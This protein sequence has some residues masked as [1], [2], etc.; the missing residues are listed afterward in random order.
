M[1]PEEIVGKFAN[2]LEQFKSINRQPSD[3]D[4]TQIREVVAPP[5]LQILYDETG[6]VH[7]FIDLIRPE[8]SYTTRYGAAFL[9]PTRVGLYNSKID[10]DATAVIYARGLRAFL[11]V[12]LPCAHI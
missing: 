1:T 4:F 8:A 11:C 10:D 6:A 9:E 2:S 12:Q 7:N 3:T 5:L